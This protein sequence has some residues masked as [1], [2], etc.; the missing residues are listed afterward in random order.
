[1]GAELFHE[2]E[3]ERETDVTKLIVPF[4]NFEKELK[5][6]YRIM[7]STLEKCRL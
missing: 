7:S 3:R 6:K 5:N 2:R 4:R 1:M